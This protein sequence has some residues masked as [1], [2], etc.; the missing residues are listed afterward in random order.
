MVAL[1]AGAAQEAEGRQG[2]GEL[3]LVQL[4]VQ[5]YVGACAPDAGAGRE[6]YEE[7]GI[8]NVLLYPADR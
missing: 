8:L 6:Y 4:S 3:E 1:S 2:A 7:F 5:D